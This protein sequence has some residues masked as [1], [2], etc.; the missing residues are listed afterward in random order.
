MKASKGI[1][2][3]VPPVIEFR[4]RSNDDAIR[5]FLDDAIDLSD[6]VNG[7]DFDEALD[8][9]HRVK[10]IRRQMRMCGPDHGFSIDERG[11]L[12]WRG[13]H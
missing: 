1:E 2:G 10:A 4:H 9:R 11:F 13:P 7:V 12:K 5:E 6:C 8:T 3:M